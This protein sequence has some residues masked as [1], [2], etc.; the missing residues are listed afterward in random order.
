MHWILSLY[1]SLCLSQG[2]P[3]MLIDPDLVCSLVSSSRSKS[4]IC[5]TDR[6]HGQ[7]F[8]FLRSHIQHYG[9]RLFGACGDAHR[10]F[11]SPHFT[12]RAAFPLLHL[13]SCFYAPTLHRLLLHCGISEDL[14]TRITDCATASLLPHCS[15]LAWNTR[16]TSRKLALIT[17]QSARLHF[18]SPATLC[19][20]FVVVNFLVALFP[21]RLV[22][23]SLKL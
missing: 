17:T 1:L 5:F 10:L 7:C 4:I 8:Y 2:R 19:P 21:P 13:L 18:V 23:C 14:L 3:V 20:P 11:N 15:R 22:S 12:Q 6:T 16:H 9:L